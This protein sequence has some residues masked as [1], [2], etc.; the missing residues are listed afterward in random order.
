MNKIRK[1]ICG[2]TNFEDAI[3]SIE[4][5]A[6]ALGFVFYEKSSRYITPEDARKIIDNLPPF[7]QCVGLFVN[8]TFKQI[9]QIAKISH[10]DIAQIH[11]EVDDKFLDQLNIRAIRV[12]RAKQKEDLQKYQDQYR[13]VDAFVQQ[14]GGEGKRLDLKWFEDIDCSK[15]IIA[16]G[17]NSSNLDELK[18]FGFFGVDVSSGVES[19]KGKKDKNKIIDFLTKANEL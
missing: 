3:V 12:I 4:A 6:D 9:N 8:H 14:Y 7:V 2:I 19:S 17:L 13:I 18:G 1:K 11:F 10:I 15:I 16:G 5:G